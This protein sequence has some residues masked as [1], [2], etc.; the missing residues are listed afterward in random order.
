MHPNRFLAMGDAE[1]IYISGAMTAR[2]MQE[3]LLPHHDGKEYPKVAWKKKNTRDE[4]IIQRHYSR[5]F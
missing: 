5:G 4:R 1:M 2:E 3:F